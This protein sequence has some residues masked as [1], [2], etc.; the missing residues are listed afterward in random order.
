MGSP[1]TLPGLSDLLATNT[2]TDLSTWNPTHPASGPQNQ[3]VIDYSAAAAKDMECDPIKGCS[4]GVTNPPA[5]TT[6]TPDVTLGKQ[7][8]CDSWYSWIDPTCAG[9]KAGARTAGGSA[10]TPLYLHTSDRS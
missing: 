6:G 7:T 10:D 2:M 5:Q 3:N 4:S 8:G 1:L 9:I